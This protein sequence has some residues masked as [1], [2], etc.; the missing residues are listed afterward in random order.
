MFE[1]T[2]QYI[3]HFLFKEKEKSFDYIDEEV[4]M[5]FV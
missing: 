4:A 5:I 3:N 1:K 2:D